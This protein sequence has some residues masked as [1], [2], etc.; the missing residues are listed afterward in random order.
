MVTLNHL[1]RICWKKYLGLK[2]YLKAHVEGPES[3]GAVPEDVRDAGFLF[4]SV[5]EHVRLGLRAF[6][7][8]SLLQSLDLRP[9][10]EMVRH[11][12]LVLPGR[13]LDDFFRLLHPAVADE[14]SHGLR[15]DPVKAEQRCGNFLLVRRASSSG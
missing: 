3:H 10:V 4:P 8:R 2:L 6:H 12:L 7:Q 15:N 9:L 13:L 14:P 5:L 11:Q 1:K